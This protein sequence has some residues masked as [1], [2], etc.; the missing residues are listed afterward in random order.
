MTAAQTQTQVAQSR[1]GK[2]PLA[3]PAGVELKVNG[4]KVMVKGPKGAMEREFPSEIKV[5]IK[6]KLV[7]VV[8]LDGTGRRGKQFQGLVRAL[9]GNMVEGA[10]KGFAISLDLIGV[11]YRAEVKGQQL[12]LALGL[13]HPV[14][15]KLPDS[16]QARVEIIDEAGIKKPRLH[17]SSYDKMMLGQTAAR[18]RSFRP[19]EPYKGKGVRYTGERVREKAGKAGGGK[20]G[21][22][23]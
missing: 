3:L 6:D 21:K 23:K 16:V 15:F 12:N 22:A 18:I 7:H 17:L 1:V 13:S 11:G 20:A 5:E 14:Q 4:R 19:P 2:R 10:A 9:L 8:P